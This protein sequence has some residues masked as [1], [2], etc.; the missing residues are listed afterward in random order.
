MVHTAVAYARMHNRL[1]AL[2]CT[3]SIGPGATNMVTGAALATINRLPVLLH[4]GDVFAA[5]TARPRAAAARGAVGGRRLRER[6]LPPGVALLRPHLAAGAG[7]PGRALRAAGAHEPCRHRRRHARVPAGRP[8]GS[9]RLPRGAVRGAHV[10]RATAS[11]GRDSLAAAVDAIRTAH[12]RSSSPAAG[13]STPRRPRRCAPSA[14]RPASRW[15]RPRPGRARCRLTIRPTSVRSG[16]PAR[17]RR[18]AS[19]REPIW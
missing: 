16:R 10:A 5:R 2:V 19:R 8:G 18:T 9:V 1:G 14:R 4:P 7:D 17:S 3:S 6:C 11:A 12:G 15:A 13:S